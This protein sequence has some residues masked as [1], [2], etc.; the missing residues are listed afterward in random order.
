MIQAV[1]II[2]ETGQCIFSHKYITLD[3][4][5]QL[6]SGLLMAFDAFSSESGIGGVQQIGGEDNQ[7]VYGSSGKLLVAALADRRDSEDLV[8]KLMGKIAERFHEKYASYVHDLTFV[9]LNVFN[10]FEND[11]DQILF[12]KAYNRGA[13]S[14]IFGTI[15]SLALTVGIFL[16]LNEYIMYASFLIF[17]A[18]I[19]GLFI[20][21][22]IAGKSSYGIISSL[23][24]ML[25]IIG[26]IAYL[27]VDIGNTQGTP[28]ESTINSIFLMAVTYIT[29][30]LLCGMLG[31]GIIDRRRLFPLDK[32]TQSAVVIPQA[33][34]LPGQEQTTSQEVYSAAE[35]AFQSSEY[36]AEEP[37][38][39]LPP[40]SSPEL[41]Q[42]PPPPEP[43]EQKD[44]WDQN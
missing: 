14:T 15:I 8:E 10:G 30:A 26:Y 40:D 37:P 34:V 18:F 3:I 12:R 25:P 38:Q 21:A 29:I 11:I 44:E 43:Y 39:D 31:G 19:P 6:I 27:M 32:H 2:T 42:Q 22:L 20:G 28:I 5:D 33:V 24:T 4:D 1:W 7:F 35:A 41:P 9:D 17:L 36:F 16:V 23:I 13:G